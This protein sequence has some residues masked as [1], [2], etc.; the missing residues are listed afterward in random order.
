MCNRFF[1]TLL[2]CKFI[3]LLLFVFFPFGHSGQ[4]DSFPQ[5]LFFK[6]LYCLS[7]QCFWLPEPNGLKSLVSVF[8]QSTRLFQHE[9]VVVIAVSFIL[10]F[11]YL[12]LFGLRFLRGWTFHTLLCAH[13]VIVCPLTSNF[14]LTI[15]R[16][17]NWIVSYRVTGN[18]VDVSFSLALSFLLCLS[19]C[20]LAGFFV[21]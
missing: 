11:F 21:V 13:S 3:V 14:V 1:F 6:F 15:H 4:F 9:F 8:S 2:V 20:M 18:S 5:L 16:V 7:Q 19:L 17:F 10:S 12:L